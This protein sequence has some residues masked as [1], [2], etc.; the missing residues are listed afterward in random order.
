MLAASGGLCRTGPRRVIKF[1]FLLETIGRRL[2]RLT[3]IERASREVR[4]GTL[5]VSSFSKPVSCERIVFGVI[6]HVN[7]SWSE[8]PR[9]EFSQNALRSRRKAHLICLRRSAQNSCNC[10]N[11][12][13]PS[14]SVVLIQ[15]SFSLMEFS[16]PKV[17]FGIKRVRH[18]HA[19]GS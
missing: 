13:G 6:S 1:L 5:P 4:C 16:Y 15:V 19:G 14:F 18:V 3:V 2:V 7:R 11:K 8:K 10:S 17:G 9:Q 12:L